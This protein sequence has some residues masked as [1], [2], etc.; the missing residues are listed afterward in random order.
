MVATTYDCRS[1]EFSLPVGGLLRVV[2]ERRPRI[3]V[4]INN[5]NDQAEES[6]MNSIIFLLLG[7]AG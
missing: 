3:P 6:K 4:L 5:L 7:T 2:L 1:A